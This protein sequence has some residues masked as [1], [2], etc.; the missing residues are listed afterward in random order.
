MEGLAATLY[1]ISGIL[2]LFL[3][4][5]ALVCLATV[6]R[7]R[8]LA[9]EVLSRRLYVLGTL[10]MAIVPLLVI[11]AAIVLQANFVYD[12]NC[13]GFTDGYWPCSRADFV[14]ADASF[15]L[16]ILIPVALLHVPATLL[17][18]FLGW[19]RRYSPGSA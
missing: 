11:E 7:N 9:R 16:F 12:G 4:V 1:G 10:V 17:V 13:Y 15:G 18:F 2:L 14:I 6:L 8:L 3:G 19:R 5:P